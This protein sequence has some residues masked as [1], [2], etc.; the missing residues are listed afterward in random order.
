MLYKNFEYF[1]NACVGYAKYA[2]YTL[3]ANFGKP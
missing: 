1:T 2:R 3:S